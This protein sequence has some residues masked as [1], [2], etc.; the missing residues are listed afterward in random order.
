MPHFVIKSF[1]GNPQH[2]VEHFPAPERIPKEDRPFEIAR[3]EL[4]DGQAGMSVDA[5]TALVE[6][7]KLKKWEPTG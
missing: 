2:S 4:T 1:N 7:G 6:A 5:L 3:Y